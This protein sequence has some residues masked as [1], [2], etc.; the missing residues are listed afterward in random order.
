MWHHLPHVLERFALLAL[1]QRRFPQT[2]QVLQEPVRLLA[3]SR[4]FA[5]GVRNQ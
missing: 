3:E 5:S 1:T 4:S 2:M